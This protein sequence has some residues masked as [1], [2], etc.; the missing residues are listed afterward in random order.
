MATTT[1]TKSEAIKIGWEAMKKNFW[2]FAGLLIITL[3]IEI[4]P[5]AIAD[6]VKEKMLA[7]YILLTIAAWVLQLIVE[8]GVV[9]ITLDVLDKGTGNIGDLFSRVQL[10]GK[11]IIGTLLYGLIVIGGLIL[12]IVP[13]I[14]WAIKYQFYS[15][16]I[17]DKNLG[18]VE[19]LKKSGEITLGNKGNLLL[20]GFLFMLINLAGA[21]F[22][23]VGLL[24]TIPT[25]MVATAYVYRKLMNEIDSSTLKEPTPLAPAKQAM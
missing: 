14:I 8:M 13:G 24:A 25:T 22:F 9:K 12:L 20:L 2:F 15:Y 4:I 6:S 19:A 5:T 10:V 23:L 18:P 16:L 3:L 1:F 11:F 21:L 7:L 17:I